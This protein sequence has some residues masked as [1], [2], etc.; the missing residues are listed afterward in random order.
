MLRYRPKPR[1]DIEPL[2]Y[3]C[4]E[5]ESIREKKDVGASAPYT[6]DPILQAYRFCNLRRRDDKVSRWLIQNVLNNCTQFT[7]WG[8]LQFAAFCRWVNWPPTLIA[9]RDAGFWPACSFD[10]EAIGDFLDCELGGKVWTGAYM[11][12]APDGD[13]KHMGKGMFISTIV[14]RDGLESVRDSLLDAIRGNSLEGTWRALYGAKFWGSFMAGQVVVDLSYTPSYAPFLSSASD[15]T[16]WAPQGPGS[17]RGYHRLL[18]NPLNS[19][20]PDQEVWCKQL[21]EWRMRVIE[22]LGPA[23]NDLMLHDIQNALCEVDKYLRVKNG[24]GRPRA[25]YISHEGVY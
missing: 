12:R 10:F 24:E 20:A 14:I 22:V 11:I 13:Y 23:Y 2:L 8:F 25:T 21:F 3:W 7:E 16:T 18:G 4:K 19:K 1:G 9:L 15:L 5:R 6:A 17:L